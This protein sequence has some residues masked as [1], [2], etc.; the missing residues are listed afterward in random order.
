MA[1]KADKLSG[2]DQA[3]INMRK[4]KDCPPR[5]PLSETIILIPQESR[6]VFTRYLDRKIRETQKYA[7]EIKNSFG[8]DVK[9][10]NAEA[11]LKHYPNIYWY[12]QSS[13]ELAVE[14]LSTHPQVIEGLLRVK[15]K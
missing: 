11:V 15:Q 2:G 8:V 9:K 5:L 6:A 1:R 12:S 3:E 7:N 14:Y 4:E 10:L 13:I